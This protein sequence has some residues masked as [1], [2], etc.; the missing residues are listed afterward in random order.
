MFAKVMSFKFHPNRPKI[1]KDKGLY[2]QYFLHLQRSY[3]SPMHFG[4][5]N[6]NGH[7]GQNQR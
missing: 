1:F 4:R 6:K 2:S 5:G 3:I 7:T